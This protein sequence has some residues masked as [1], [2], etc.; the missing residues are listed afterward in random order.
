VSQNGELSDFDLTHIHY[1][2][3]IL[4]IGVTVAFLGRKYLDALSGMQ[5]FSIQVA[6]GVDIALMVAFSF[7][8]TVLLTGR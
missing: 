6:P 5:E 2:A 1:L 4:G 3:L 8:W 7:V